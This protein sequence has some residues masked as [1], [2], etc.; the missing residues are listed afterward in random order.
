LKGSVV[1]HNRKLYISLAS[2]IIA[3]MMF[4]AC[5]KK[6]SVKESTEIKETTTQ[7]SE[8]TKQEEDKVEDVKKEESENIKENDKEEVKT[9]LD[10]LKDEFVKSGFEIGENEEL[11]FAMMGAT[12]GYKY[13]INGQLAEFYIYEADKLT[14]EGK[15]LFEQAKKG[16]VSMGGFNFKVDYVNGFVITR[17]DEHKDKDKIIEVVKNFNQ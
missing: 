7:A 14:D 10:S 6:E 1:M 8:T 5:G 3:G 16:S 2:I 12:N 4:S 9:P 17:L 11:A 13:K 15:E